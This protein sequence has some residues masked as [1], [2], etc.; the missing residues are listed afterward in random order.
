MTIERAIR[1]IAS[2]GKCDA[3]ELADH[4][5]DVVIEIL[6]R[7]RALPRRSHPSW[8]IALASTRQR[9]AEHLHRH[10]DEHVDREDVVRELRE[11]GLLDDA[12]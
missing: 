1:D 2:L 6:Q 8:S 12:E 11:Y 4:A 3:E 7:D 5:I 10:I 9:I